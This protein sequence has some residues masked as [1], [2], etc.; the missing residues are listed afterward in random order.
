MSKEMIVEMPKEGETIKVR[1]PGETPFAMCVEVREGTWMGCILN[2]L[3]REYSEIEQAR[4][5]G[6]H[7]K[8][9]TPLPELHKYKKFGVIEFAPS[10]HPIQGNQGWEPVI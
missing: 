3:F 6:Q 4:W 1:L 7:F 9:Y 8:E 5:T 2:K 10:E